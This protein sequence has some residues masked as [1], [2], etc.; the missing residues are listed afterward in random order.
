MF[1]IPISFVVLA[2]VAA[3]VHVLLTERR[4]ASAFT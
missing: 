2:V 3:A 1:G 4:S